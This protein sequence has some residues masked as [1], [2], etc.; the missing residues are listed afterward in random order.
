MEPSGGSWGKVTGDWL[1]SWK[2][3]AEA[4]LFERANQA[5]DTGSSCVFMADLYYTWSRQAVKGSEWSSV[6]AGNN[7]IALLTLGPATLIVSS[8]VIAP[9]LNAL[10]GL[11]D[12]LAAAPP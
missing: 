12:L 5:D 6:H 10:A 3:S 9:D 4:L 11:P 2:R 8:T 7:I 1:A